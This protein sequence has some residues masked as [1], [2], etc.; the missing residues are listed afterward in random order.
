MHHLNPMEDFVVLKPR[1]KARVVDVGGVGIGGDNPIRVQ[2]MTNTD[3]LEQCDRCLWKWFL[4]IDTL[5]N[6]G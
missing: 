3:T 5:A 6:V 4:C 2:T 1:R